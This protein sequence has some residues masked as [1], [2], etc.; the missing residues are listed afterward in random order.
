[1]DVGDKP[2]V[3]PALATQRTY[4]ARRFFHLKDPLCLFALAIRRSIDPCWVDRAA[5]RCYP[6]S[7]KRNRG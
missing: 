7:F 3:A 5:A 6:F 4:R 2:A 1:M